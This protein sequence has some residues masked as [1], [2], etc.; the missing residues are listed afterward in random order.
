MKPTKKRE[1]IALLNRF[2][3]DFFKTQTP[4]CEQFKQEKELREKNVL[5]SQF[6]IFKFINENFISREKS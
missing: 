6:N 2:A 3:Q 4:Q 5:E 1:L